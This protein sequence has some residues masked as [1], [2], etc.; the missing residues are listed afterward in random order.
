MRV[1]ALISDNPN[2]PLSGSRVRNHYLWPELRKLGVEVRILGHWSS[3]TRNGETDPE[4]TE[5]FRCDRYTAPVRLWKALTH[6]YHEWPLST[7][8]RERMDQI[9]TDW[10]PDIVHAEEL[11]MAGYFFS[12]AK[13]A[14]AKTSVTFHNVE[15]ELIRQTGS[16]P[17]R[18]GQTIINRAHRLNLGHFERKVAK[19]VD[20]AI[21]FSELD[22]CKYKALY[23]S[24]NWVG[25]RNGTAASRIQPASAPRDASVLWLGSLSYAPN[26]D[27]LFW[28]M[29]RVV[30]LLPL[31]LKITVGGSRPSAAV[32]EKMAN[33]GSR[34]E[35]VDT[36]LELG[37]LYEN[38]TVCV[39]PLFQG[40]GTRGK[41]LESLAYERAVVTTQVGVEGLEMSEYQGYVLADGGPADFANQVMRLCGDHKRRDEIALAGREAVLKKYDWSVVASQLHDQWANLLR[42]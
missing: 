18:L 37:P 31:D 13:I 7:P 4:G 20:L 24:A 40:S 10:R 23:P 15:S 36:P 30:P 2:P 17:F 33:A 34:F 12:G 21:A 14:H 39:V 29:D 16:S 25:S 38:A 28:F 27:G 42:G 9:I 19:S 41:I 8:L 3:C 26:I 22:R 32:R 1:L 6:S 11:K 35:F 5:Y